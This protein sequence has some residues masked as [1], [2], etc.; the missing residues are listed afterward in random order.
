MGGLVIA[1][2]LILEGCFGG[3]R[4]GGWGVWLG[5]R[6]WLRVWMSMWILGGETPKQSMG[7]GT[8]GLR[9]HARAVSSRSGE[10]A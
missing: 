6:V 8:A 2:L 4:V 9:R 7:A 1:V 10:R 3:D 5:L